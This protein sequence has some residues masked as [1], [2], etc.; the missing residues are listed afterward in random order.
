M[1]S[2]QATEIHKSMFP[3]KLNLV[4]STHKNESHNHISNTLE[5]SHQVHGEHYNPH[6]IKN[7]NNNS[8]ETHDKEH[9]TFQSHIIIP[10]TNTVQRLQSPQGSTELVTESL[11]RPWGKSKVY[12][13]K[14]RIRKSNLCN[15]DRN[16]SV[17]CI[18]YCLLKIDCIR[19][20]WKFSSAGTTL[21]VGSRWFYSYSRFRRDSVVHNAHLLALAQYLI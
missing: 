19:I 8:Q 7:N 4:F 16:W 13:R 21:L 10:K 20:N 12:K 5:T 9:F 1:T 3:L 14:L 6:D 17:T 15:I 11:G 18:D 2:N